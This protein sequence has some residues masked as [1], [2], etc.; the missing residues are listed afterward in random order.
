MSIRSKVV[1]T[2][3]KAT[4][5]DEILDFITLGWYPRFIHRVIENMNPLQGE[6]F[7]ELGVGNGRNARLISQ[8]VGKEGEVI[9]FDVSMEMLNRARQKTRGYDNIKIIK[10]SILE[11]YPEEY[12]NYF[13]AALI[14]FV[15][16][17]FEDWEKDRIL[18]N[19]H[20]ILK[21]GG[22][23]YILDYEQVD[24]EK[25]NIL[26][27]LFMHRIECPLAIE[28]LNYKLSDKLIHYGF[29]Q[30]RKILY[31]HGLIQLSEFIIEK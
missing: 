8:K 5:Y 17:G 18:K 24:F 7:V 11:A 28:F 1:I 16:H 26:Y 22:R 2:G 27:R 9:G 19:L 31:L 4:H 29:E 14:V 12:T 13:D 15:F 30:K 3:F 6:K 23:F 25:Q 10:H 20:R 21:P